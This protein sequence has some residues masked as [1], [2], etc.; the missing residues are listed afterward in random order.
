MSS[1]THYVTPTYQSLLILG[2]DTVARR[3]ADKQVFEAWQAL[4][5]LYVELPPECQKECSK[6]FEKVKNKLSE[7]QKTKGYSYYAISTYVNRAKL[8][9]LSEA[10][11]NLF[12]TFKNSLF[13]KGYL[14]T[15]PTKPRNPQPKT[16]G[17]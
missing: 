5:T 3:L 6:E 15:A 8:V 10:N 7:I 13:T 14:E 1:G 17:E 11:L 16:L 2:L 9:Y 12:N 4:K